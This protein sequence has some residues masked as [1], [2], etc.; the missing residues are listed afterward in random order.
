MKLSAVECRTDTMFFFYK[1]LSSKHGK[2]RVCSSLCVHVCVCTYV[3]EQ[4]VCVGNITVDTGHG[5]PS[6]VCKSA[7]KLIFVKMLN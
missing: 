1:N 2:L 5:R 6:L 7:H 3:R 4:V